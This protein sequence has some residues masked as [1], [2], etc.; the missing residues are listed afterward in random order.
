MSP[1]CSDWNPRT[2]V[3]S[4]M[5]STDSTR[6]L[7]SRSACNHQASLR[8]KE[9]HDGSAYI[10][11][12]AAMCSRRLCA[13]MVKKHLCSAGATLCS[14]TTTQAVLISFH[15]H[16]VTSNMFDVCSRPSHSALCQA[17]LISCRHVAKRLLL[18]TKPCMLDALM[19]Q[20]GRSLRE[21]PWP[22]QVFPVTTTCSRNLTSLPLLPL[23]RRHCLDYLLSLCDFLV[24]PLLK[25]RHAQD[26]C[27]LAGRPEL[28][29]SSCSWVACCCA[30]QLSLLKVQLADQI[31]G[32]LILLQPSP[33]LLAT[34]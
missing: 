10:A 6:S 5:A 19:L 8:A 7:K 17:A 14:C 11:R 2:S 29:G 21:C 1:T 3:P 30:L 28:A 31:H 24:Q 13:Y 16:H 20:I 25:V 9:C 4:C 22:N 34:S 32:M 18:T 12:C 27:A 15:Y 33:L 26:S 23:M